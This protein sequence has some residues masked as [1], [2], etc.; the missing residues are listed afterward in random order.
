MFMLSAALL[1]GSVLLG[2]VDAG[3]DDD[4]KLTVRRLVYQL[5]SDRLSERQSAEEELLKLGP[6]ALDLLPQPTD[7][8]SAEV[9]QRVARVRQKLQ[10]LAARAAGEPSLI[11]LRGDAIPLSKVL[12]ALAEQSG[13]KIVDFRSEFGQQATDPPLKVDFDKTSFWEA[14]DQ[15]LDQA[16]VRLY[17][18]G[19]EKAI[20][21]V[22]RGGPQR[23]RVGSACYS[24]PLRIE[25]IR[26]LA[27][28]E[29]RQAE[30]D[31]LQ[32]MLSVDWEP[33]LS[34]ISLS[35]KTAEIR[36]VDQQDRPLAIE[37]VGPVLNVPTSGATS[38][39]LTLPF[40]LPSRDVKQIASL[41][42]KLTAM[43]PG[44]V[45][46]FTFDR[47][48][49]AK[50]VD[51]RVAGVTVTL[52]RVQR[53]NELWQVQ[54]QVQFDDASGALA[55]HLGWIYDN[56]A[57]LED[58]AG[59]PVPFDSQEFG[60]QADNQIGVGYLFVL[61]GPLDGY[62]FVY[63]TPGVIMSTDFDYEIKAIDLP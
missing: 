16:E 48:T 4:L 43:I 27:R 44:K 45:E 39:Q 3:A 36:A 59:K 37:D 7:R 10:H 52:N 46:T 56:E 12:A 42:G 49:E 14:L 51:K 35:Q 18:F 23:P 40:Q 29:F 54:M 6:A 50:D 34:P 13:N 15:V 20:N 5:D 31:S 22:A 19:E 28:R 47:L 41:K 24:G 53:N 25:P 21:F 63:K 60:R 2:Q 8:H 61:E 62:K 17:G 33:R 32:L 1:V 55:S 30:G 11:T 26:M 9:L 38:V 58:P 57:Y